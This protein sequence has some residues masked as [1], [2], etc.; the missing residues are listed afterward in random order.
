M[1]AMPTCRA[2][3]I[4]ETVGLIRIVPWDVVSE[5]NGRHRCEAVVERV[6]V[7][8]AA[9]DGEEYAGWDEKDDDEK[10]RED[11]AEVG[12][13]DV[14]GSVQV[15]EATHQQTKQSRG[16]QHQALNHRREEDQRQRNAKPRVEHAEHFSSLR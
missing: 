16:D 2:E 13:T 4:E 8:P 5:A 11:D 6:Q 3:F 9:L 10:E 14:D 15:S 1:G 12:Q 7:V